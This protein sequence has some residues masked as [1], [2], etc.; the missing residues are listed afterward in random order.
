MKIR[1]Y[2][3]SCPN[4]ENEIQKTAVEFCTRFGGCTQYLAQGLWNGADGL[5]AE[6]V[7]VLESTASVAAILRFHIKPIAQRIKKNLNQEAVLYE[8]GGVATLV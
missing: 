2:I 1:I 3:P 7:T 8:R 6:P 5:C 4:A